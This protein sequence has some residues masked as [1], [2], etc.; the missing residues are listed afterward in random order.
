[1]DV[2]RLVDAWIDAFGDGYVEPQDLIADPSINAILSSLIGKDLIA[3]DRY[4]P[5]RVGRALSKI[6]GISINGK[7]LE[8]GVQR[9]AGSGGG[10][11]WTLR[12]FTPALPKTEKV[13]PYL[14]GKQ[15]AL[16]SILYQC[17]RCGGRGHNRATCKAEL[18]TSNEQSHPVT[19]LPT[20]TNA[21]I[22][23]FKIYAVHENKA[24]TLVVHDTLTDFRTY[25]VDT[26]DGPVGVWLQRLTATALPVQPAA[27]SDEDFAR[28]Y[29]DD[30]PL[31]APT[32]TKEV[33]F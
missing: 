30:E 33:P 3:G 13:T 26:A 24:E 29:Y 15:S 1:M 32:S 10:A 11:S 5:G 17:R 31:P 12:D 9:G 22:I 20:V 4:A 23:A 27:V 19:E 14:G 2:R 8:R 16:G 25:E 28:W 21:R 6:A 7:Q 18:Q